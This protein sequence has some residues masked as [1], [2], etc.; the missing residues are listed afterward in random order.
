MPYP[1][2]ASAEAFAAWTPERQARHWREA[3]TASGADLVLSGV[4][5]YD[6]IAHSLLAHPA[7]HAL[8]IQLIGFSVGS[9]AI[10]NDIPLLLAG[11]L[12]LEA[13]EWWRDDRLY[14]VEV[15]L[16]CSLHDISMLGDAGA[17]AS[18]GNRRAELTS[19]AALSDQVKMS[20]HERATVVEHA[21]SFLVPAPFLGGDA[22]KEHHNLRE[23]VAAELLGEWVQQ[24]ALR[25]QDLQ[26]A[27]GMVPFE[28][29]ELS[30]VPGKG[31]EPWALTGQV[32]LDLRQLDL[33]D[34]LRIQVDQ[35]PARVEAL[36][37]GETPGLFPFHV[38]LP[39]VREGSSVRL[40]VRD[41]GLR[42]GVRTFT[43]IAGLTGTRLEKV[44][45]VKLAPSPAVSHHA[46]GA[47]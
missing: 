34:G 36:D 35:N 31:A 18:I 24:F 27:R 14:L 23:T 1:E 11:V 32:R 25:E 8:W 2:E 10:R 22:E 7:V 6:P 39:T 47:L 4:L 44:L 33:M 29:E 43:W 17:G 12:G 30:L 40:D 38:S 21:L 5:R 41:G 26:R 46:A 37:E 3:A 42:Q 45:R 28:V 13:S 16:D 9:V 19:V 20:F 15:G